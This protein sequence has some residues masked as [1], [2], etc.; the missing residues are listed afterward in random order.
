VRERKSGLAQLDT[1]RDDKKTLL[2]EAEKDKASW[3]RKED[4]LLAE[5]DRLAADLR[6]LGE[7]AGAVVGTGQFVW[8]VNGRVSSPF[9][10]RIHPIFHV[11]KM[12]TGIDLSAGMG[13]PIKAADSGTVVQAGWR[14][15]YGKC[16]VI[17][18]G[19][20]VA[21]LYAHQSVISVSVGDT[22]ERGQAIGN[23]GST[24]YSTGA[25]LHFEVRVDGS[26][27]DP[28]RYL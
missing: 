16:V 6:A 9:G 2:A 4:S 12:H 28:M 20:G 7:R 8:P 25:H 17:S 19:N 23:V 15:G 10:Y 13:T 27:V 3:E 14:G 26:P 21:T 11:R 18:H 1:A 5:S 22:V 24:G